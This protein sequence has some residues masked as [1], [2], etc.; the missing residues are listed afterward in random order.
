MFYSQEQ[1]IPTTKT[2]STHPLPQPH[3]PTKESPLFSYYPTSL[4]STKI[5]KINKHRKI[6]AVNTYMIYIAIY[7]QRTI[8]S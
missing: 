1:S 4:P 7:I 2:K 8:T 5:N 6:A 3:T